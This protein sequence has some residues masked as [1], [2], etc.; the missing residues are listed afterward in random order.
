[1]EVTLTKVSTHKKT[2]SG[3]TPNALGR[4]INKTVAGFGM[5]TIAYGKGK[6]RTSETMHCSEAQAEARKEALQKL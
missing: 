5:Y 3:S 4:S 2:K 6:D 1:M